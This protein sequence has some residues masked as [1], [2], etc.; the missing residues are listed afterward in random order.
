LRLTLSTYAVQDWGWRRILSTVRPFHS[1]RSFSHESNEVRIVAIAQLKKRV[2]REHLE[3]LLSTYLARETY[4]YNVVTWLDRLI[5]APDPVLPYYEQ[6][7]V[8]EATGAD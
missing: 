5:Y 7:L 8:N 2:S 1:L 3:Q 6:Q 4:F